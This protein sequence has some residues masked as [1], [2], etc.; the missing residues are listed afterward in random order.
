MVDDPDCDCDCANNY[1]NEGAV[2]V[3]VVESVFD[4]SL[5]ACLIESGKIAVQSPL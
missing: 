1:S 4:K 2:V 3:V 5:V